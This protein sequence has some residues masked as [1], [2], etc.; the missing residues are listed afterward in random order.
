MAA[1]EEEG[2]DVPAEG[3]EAGEMA[4]EDV[5]DYDGNYEEVSG[6]GK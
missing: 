6:G 4:A 1:E 2:G 5:Q 3:G